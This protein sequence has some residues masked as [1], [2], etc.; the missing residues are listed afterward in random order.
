MNTF[1]W[2]HVVAQLLEI[3]EA[4]PQQ[5][6]REASCLHCSTKFLESGISS[7]D[8]STYK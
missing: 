4:V 1:T 7:Y 3:L 6:V 2:I 5:Q 8:A